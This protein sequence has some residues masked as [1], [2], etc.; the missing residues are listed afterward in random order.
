MRESI[1]S[2]WFRFLAGCILGM[3]IFML[4]YGVKIINPTYDDWIYQKS[5]DIN[6]HYIGWQFYRKSSW[7]FPIGLIEGL[8]EQKVSMMYTDSIPLF[9]VIFKVLSPLLPETFQYMGLWGIF[10]FAMQGGLGTLITAKL[11]EEQN[12]FIDLIGGSLFI[13]SETV[14]QRMFGHSALG[15][16]WLILLFI[17][18]WLCND[19]YTSVQRVIFWTLTSIL[20][21]SVHPYF[22]P[23]CYFVMFG[24]LL[25][26]LLENRKIVR[27]VL[28]PVSS[29]PFTL[30]VM[31]LNGAFYG[32]SNFSG[33]GLGKFSAN[34]NALINPIGEGNSLLI[35]PLPIIDGQGEG[36]AY[37]GAGII[38]GAVICIILMIFFT[39]K[40]RFLGISY[41]F[42]EYKNIIIPVTLVIAISS[43]LAFFPVV[44]INDKVIFEFSYPEKITE[45]LSVF[46][47]SGRFIWLTF[48]GIIVGIIAFAFRKLDNR[49]VGTIFLILCLAI[50]LIDMTPIFKRF[51]YYKTEMKYTSPFKDSRW[52]ELGTIYDEICFVPK[53]PDFNDY[54]DNYYAFA[55]YAVKHNMNMSSFIIARLD[56]DK[57]TE[58]T[59]NQSEKLA[60][61]KPEKD[62]L[63]I[64]TNNFEYASDNIINEELDGY[65]V[66][67]STR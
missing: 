17:W 19:E 39:V 37:L 38:F 40:N 5:G 4:I 58:Y 16:Q 13:F 50:Q 54:M 36:Y 48:Y 29:I 25:Y 12:I 9:A 11:E 67:H 8:S 59:E 66:C 55:I 3:I 7:S 63:Y 28:V 62:K 53:V 51:S 33:G 1:N 21:V 24:T 42:S 32:G 46:R 41:F 65:V 56:F 27:D 43:Y 60:Q 26:D 22:V 20:S 10:C 14:I 57:M 34:L 44:V 47:A 35:K 2:R 6:Q 49:K 52:E 30:L 15:G 31:W 23:M 45:L 64:I 18:L 61:G